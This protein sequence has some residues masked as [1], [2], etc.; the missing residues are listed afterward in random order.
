M[1]KNIKFVIFFKLK[2]HQNPFSGPLG[3]LIYDAP[4]TPSRMVWGHPPSPRFLPLDGFG[5]SI[6]DS[7][8]TR[9]EVVI[10]P[11][12]NGFQG[13]AVALDGPAAVSK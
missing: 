1:T 3:E 10:G 2:M 4:Q 13:P 8:R 5:V 11:R 7:R 9:N 12:D 6:S